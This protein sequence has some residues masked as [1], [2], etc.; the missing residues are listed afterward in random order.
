MT[1]KTIHFILTILSSLYSFGCA[2]VHSRIDSPSDFLK[3]K[4][5]Y[6]E[7]PH[8][9]QLNL[10]GMIKEQLQM[11]GFKVIE[12][13]SSIS[14]EDADVIVVFSYPEDS[15]LSLY[16][17]N[18]KIEFLDAKDRKLIA[19]SSYHMTEQWV[20]KRTRVITIFNDLRMKLG[21]PLIDQN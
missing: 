20:T 7:Y 8:L 15:D 12:K 16:P 1:L 3:Y 18:I 2:N 4:T 13:N 6:L 14:Q 21:M 19:A 9:D 11:M 10:G 17:K 5:A